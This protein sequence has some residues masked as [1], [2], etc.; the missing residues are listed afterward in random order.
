M[1]QDMTPEQAG[2][3]PAQQPINIDAIKAELAA[4][5][6]KI[7]T[8]N[9]NDIVF[10]EY[11]KGDFQAIGIHQQI[12]R[13]TAQET[14]NANTLRDLYRQ[15]HERE[16]CITLGLTEQEV[17]TKHI[18]YVLRTDDKPL[19]TTK[20]SAITQ[21]RGDRWIASYGVDGTTIKLDQLYNDFVGRESVTF[22][23]TNFKRLPQKDQLELRN[24]T[25]FQAWFAE[26]YSQLSEIL[27]YKG[28]HDQLTFGLP[29][30]ICLGAFNGEDKERVGILHPPH[31]I[32]YSIRGGS[33]TGMTT[34]APLSLGFPY[35]SPLATYPC[36]IIIMYKPTETK[37]LAVQG[38]GISDSTF[39]D[40]VTGEP[41]TIDP[42]HM[43]QIAA[44]SNAENA[45]YLA[46]EGL[47]DTENSFR[48]AA[49]NQLDRLT[50][51]RK[52]M[53]ELT[54]VL[55]VACM[56]LNHHV[57]AHNANKINTFFD[58]F[59]TPENLRKA[60]SLIAAREQAETRIENMQRIISGRNSR[61]N[62]EKE[63]KKHLNNI[64]LMAQTKLTAITEQ[65][66]KS[67]TGEVSSDEII[68]KFNA[69][70][71]Y[72]ELF[73]AEKALFLAVRNQEKNVKEGALGAIE[74]QASSGNVQVATSLCTYYSAKQH[75]E[76]TVRVGQQQMQKSMVP[77]KQQINFAQ[78]IDTK[79]S[80]ANQRLS[81]TFTSAT[82]DSLTTELNTAQGHYQRFFSSR[83]YLEAAIQMG[84]HITPTSRNLRRIIGQAEA[85]LT[86]IDQMALNPSQTEKAIQDLAV[87]TVNCQAFFAARQALE[88]L[89]QADPIAPKSQAKAAREGLSAI[90]SKLVKKEITPEDAI[91]QLADLSAEYQFASKR[92]A[93]KAQLQT[94]LEKEPNVDLQVSL[95]QMISDLDDIDVSAATPQSLLFFALQ[96]EKDTIAT[97]TQNKNKYQE[98][99]AE[100]RPPFNAK[101]HQIYN[102]KDIPKMAQ[103]LRSSILAYSENEQDQQT[104]QKALNQ[105]HDLS[106]DLSH[107]C[108]SFRREY[109][110]AAIRQQL[111]IRLTTT[112]TVENFE[113]SVQQALQ[114][115]PPVVAG[116]ITPQEMAQ[117]ALLP[118]S[119]QYEKYQHFLSARRS[120]ETVIQSAHTLSTQSAG[121][122]AIVAVA[123]QERDASISRAG[124]PP[125]FDLAITKL[126]SIREL[127]PAA[128]DLQK[129]INAAKKAM[130]SKLPP[131]Q[132]DHIEL[133]IHR[134]EQL[135]MVIPQ[136][137]SSFNPLVIT[138]MTQALLQVQTNKNPTT[139]VTDAT[140]LAANALQQN[141]EEK[142]LALMENYR[143]HDFGMAVRHIIR[144]KLKF[145]NP[146]LLAYCVEQ[147]AMQETTLKITLTVDDTFEKKQEKAL[148][149]TS[150]LDAF[151]KKID[152]RIALIKAQNELRETI[153]LAQSCPRSAIENARTVLHL[154][155]DARDLIVATHHLS[156]LV[157]GSQPEDNLPGLKTLADGLKAKNQPATFSWKPLIWVGFAA[158]FLGPVGWIGGTALIIAG[159]VGQHRHNKQQKAIQAYEKLHES[160]PQVTTQ[161]PA[162]IAAPAVPAAIPAVR[163][164]E[165]VVAPVTPPPPQLPDASHH[166]A[167]PPLS[168][169]AALLTGQL[170]S[171]SPPSPPPTP[172]GT[173][174]NTM[175][176]TQ[177]QDLVNSITTLSSA[178]AMPEEVKAALVSTVQRII[179]TAVSNDAQLTPQA[180]IENA[181]VDTAMAIQETVGSTPQV[182]TMKQKET[183]EVD[184]PQTVK[185]IVQIVAQAVAAQA[186]IAQAVVAE[187]MAIQA[188]QTAM[189]TAIQTAIQAAQARAVRGESPSEQTRSILTR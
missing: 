47:S 137:T 149:T 55:T 188:V 160:L 62:E 161:P 75:F 181:A 178:I 157:S 163:Q 10:P 78:V 95:R 128:M 35:E 63:Q 66:A 134:A 53:P 29:L 93:L 86:T 42:S 1:M 52:K 92:Q 156:S 99:E 65:I 7:S 13:E 129:E 19:N 175:Y 184:I 68:A 67:F 171:S 102:T 43:L 33:L 136:M 34:D 186:V 49:R 26:N 130:S 135:L 88:E 11:L 2:T 101:L 109:A 133:A 69:L 8:R 177:E 79:Q 58:D 170:V 110:L 180:T 74:Q 81:S 31:C 139:A 40:I 103:D 71:Q 111:A 122:K 91:N 85:Q 189:Q 16:I 15:L 28:V 106:H 25:K 94:D 56:L 9:P 162:T 100:L 89:L 151:T 90:E 80:E 187:T 155:T 176:A 115:P 173:A 50:E 124:T 145:P 61:T 183:H 112:E 39:F 82:L 77:L 172:R 32:D 131:L 73:D 165:A 44:F 60:A 150:A 113:T 167:V 38:I 70:T 159:A 104:K 123:Q 142:T 126:N 48:I 27:Q 114:T 148:E 153:S 119:A 6:R 64:A 118:L 108:L 22:S 83:R 166:S 105:S 147:L 14:P 138:Q 72:K 116:H 24:E 141:F 140:K 20:N 46:I 84:R 51:L 121:L 54:G 18:R 37:N 185:I 59:F 144:T 87:L 30:N 125:N 169:S 3:M 107:A 36:R 168:T 132:K 120:L 97:A 41:Q 45:T 146:D 17:K 127:L 23:G 57:I 76:E 174:K 154:A 96:T 179:Q 152:E 182:T 117:K 5:D 4:A 143:T 12:L 21:L 158:L 98:K 164:E